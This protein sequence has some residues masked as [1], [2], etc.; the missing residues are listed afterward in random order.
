MKKRSFKKKIICLSFLLF[1]FSLD[2]TSPTDYSAKQPIH[3]PSNDINSL[4]NTSQKNLKSCSKCQKE[5]VY[6]LKSILDKDRESFEL[7]KKIKNSVIPSSSYA[8]HNKNISDC[9]NQNNK[10]KKTA[11]IYFFLICSIISN[12]QFFKFEKIEKINALLQKIPLTNLTHSIFINIA[13][14]YII[15]FITSKIIFSIADFVEE[16]I[17]GK[18]TIDKEQLKQLNEKLKQEIAHD[19]EK[20]QHYLEGLYEKWNEK[21]KEKNPHIRLQYNKKINLNDVESLNSENDPILSNILGTKKIIKYINEEIPQEI[22]TELETVENA[23]NRI[24]TK[25]INKYKENHKKIE[26]SFQ[27]IPDESSAFNN[28][29]DNLSFLQ[30]I[31]SVA[32]DSLIIPQI[33][34]QEINKVFNTKLS[35]FDYP[36]LLQKHSVG[37]FNGALLGGYSA[38]VFPLL[39]F[40]SPKKARFFR[41][42]TMLPLKLCSLLIHKKLFSII[43]LFEDKKI[44]KKPSFSNYVFHGSAIF[45]MMSIL[46]FLTQCIEQ[47][48]SGLQM[49]LSSERWERMEDDMH[50]LVDQLPTLQKYLN[51]TNK[52]TTDMKLL[53]QEIKKD[54]KNDEIQDN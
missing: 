14:S 12:A 9:F 36:P 20:Y 21:I 8:H 41:S 46:P 23:I 30:E 43:S 3:R 2:T 44:H 52:K 10:Y 53:I 42:L 49:T 27:E 32:S 7:I 1:L 17:K 45:A 39:Y 13:T 38:L 35:F 33:F 31:Y 51:E 6:M 34:I 37:I 19:I 54:I 11:L 50:I 18:I 16:K 4:K 48:I 29:K 5:T 26:L 24:Y 28:L 22:G 15:S 40:I 47:T 25:K